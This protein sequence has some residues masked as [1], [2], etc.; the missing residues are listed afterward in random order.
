MPR[1]ARISIG[2]VPHHVIQR[3]HNRS[4]CFFRAEDYRNYLKWLRE[5]LQECQCSLHAFVM[6][7]NHVHLLV[8]PETTDGLGQLM[9]RLGQRY[10]QYIN[11]TYQ[12]SGTLWE[13]RFRSCI[14]EAETYILNCYRYI[15]LNPVRAGMVNHPGEYYWSSYRANAQGEHLIWLTPHTLYNQLG[16]TR[17]ERL[18]AYRDLFQNHLEPGIV[19]EIRKATNSDYALGTKGFRRQVEKA[20]G[21]RVSPGKIGRPRKQGAVP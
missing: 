9:K 21:R 7:T 3:G 6:M 15:E 17:K 16:S 18:Q 1:K 13:G 14:T 5:Y 19:D 8:T 12:R 2:E 4:V 20:L 10:V 11:R